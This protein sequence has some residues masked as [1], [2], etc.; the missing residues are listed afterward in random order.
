MF[1]RC[2]IFN[3][4]LLPRY[5]DKYYRSEDK[6][7]RSQL[8][9][10]WLSR[11]LKFRQKVSEILLILALLTVSPTYNW[12]SSED[13][14]F[15]CNSSLLTSRNDR[16]KKL[17]STYNQVIFPRRFLSF[18][19][20]FMTIFL[21][22]RSNKILHRQICLTSKFYSFPL[23]LWTISHRYVSNTIGFRI[24]YFWDLYFL[25]FAHQRYFLQ[26]FPYWTLHWFS[27]RAFNSFLGTYIFNI[28][29]K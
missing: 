18:Y 1:S 23:S 3:W 10:K 12:Y 5:T 15:S 6:R 17:F 14:E 24:V 27:V 13:W 26:E 4:Y 16:T 19:F 11:N 20:L 29:L 8:S 28:C 2:S 9:K 25:G 22:R 21:M 7:S